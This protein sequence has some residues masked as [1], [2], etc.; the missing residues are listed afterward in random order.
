MSY[1]NDLLARTK[2]GKAKATENFVAT[3]RCKAWD[4]AGKGLNRVEAC[5]VDGVDLDAARAQLQEA[6]LSTNVSPRGLLSV[7]W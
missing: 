6:G 1:A 4:A 5:P 7:W 2:E 3:V